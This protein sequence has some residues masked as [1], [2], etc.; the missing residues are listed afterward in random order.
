MFLDVCVGKHVLYRGLNLHEAEEIDSEIVVDIHAS[1]WDNQ[2]KDKED[3]QYSI[4]FGLQSPAGANKAEVVMVSSG[5]CQKAGCRE[6][7]WIFDDRNL[8]HQ[9]ME[10]FLTDR[11]WLTTD[12]RYLN[13]NRNRIPKED[14]ILLP[15][16]L[17]AFVLKDR[18]WGE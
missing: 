5:G 8:N 10:E 3:W 6:N 1:L 15:H 13:D 4:D 7:D 12:I 18:K 2:D 14:L 11:P 17:F 9:V 16:R